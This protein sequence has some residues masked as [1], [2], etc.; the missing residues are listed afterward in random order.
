MEY[1]TKIIII[2]IV[3]TIVVIGIALALWFTLSGAGKNICEQIN[4]KYNLDEDNKYV[5]EKW[6]QGGP[7]CCPNSC[8]TGC[9]YTSGTTSK[10]RWK[11]DK[12]TIDQLILTFP[13][14]NCQEI[15][16]DQTNKSG[17]VCYIK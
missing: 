16:D 4:D 15:L 12:N 8:T 6:T 7:M 9:G 1:R 5:Y 11:Q 10:C 3:S 13:K 2:V 14:Y 17:Y